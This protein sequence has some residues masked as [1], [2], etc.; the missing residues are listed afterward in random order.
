MNDPGA[1][2]W[3]M[4]KYYED[5]SGTGEITPGVNSNPY[6]NDAASYR[7]EGTFPGTVLGTG[8]RRWICRLNGNGLKQGHSYPTSKL[9]N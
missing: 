5:P 2:V 8:D 6:G 3:H 9:P 4:Y 1:N 7:A